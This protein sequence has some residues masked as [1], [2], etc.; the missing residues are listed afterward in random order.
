MIPKRQRL[1]SPALRDA[2]RHHSCVVLGCN[3]PAVGVCHLPHGEWG[4]P[5]GMGQKTHDWLGAHLC[6]EHHDYTDGPDAGWI[7]RATLPAPRLID[8]GVLIISGEDHTLDL[9]F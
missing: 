6:Q 9:P 8:T 1:E 7:A 5:A 2:P 4:F 3:M